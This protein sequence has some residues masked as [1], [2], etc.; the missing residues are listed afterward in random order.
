M[1]SGLAGPAWLVG[2]PKPHMGPVAL[3]RMLEWTLR[4]EKTWGVGNRGIN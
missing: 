4:T 3:G 2:A 1:V